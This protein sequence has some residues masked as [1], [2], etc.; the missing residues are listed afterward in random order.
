MLILSVIDNGL[1]CDCGVSKTLIMT[2]PIFQ[3]FFPL[4]WVVLIMNYIWYI[5][6]IESYH[7]LCVKKTIEQ[8]YRNMY[9]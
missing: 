6:F 4:K 8:I 1:N 3:E 2:S 5:S 7:F 9:H